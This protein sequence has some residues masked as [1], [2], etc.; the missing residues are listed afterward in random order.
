MISVG[1]EGGYSKKGGN[2]KRESKYNELNKWMKKLKN[3]IKIVPIILD[4]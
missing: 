4:L 3:Q 1:E 2:A